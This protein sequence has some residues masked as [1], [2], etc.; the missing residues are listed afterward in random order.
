MRKLSDVLADQQRPD[1]RDLRSRS[2]AKRERKSREDWLA[3]LAQ[4]LVAL[5]PRHVERLA[6]PEPLADAI[7][8]ARAI[9]SPIARARQLRLVRRALREVDADALARRVQEVTSPDGRSG[10]RARLVEHWAGRLVAEGDAA[11]D[12]FLKDFPGATPT[13]LRQAARS[14]RGDRPGG[15]RWRKLRQVVAEA[16]EPEEP[17]EGEAGGEPKADDETVASLETETETETEAGGAGS[18]PR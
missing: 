4:D 12:A 7:R 16:L 18:E 3:T 15:P 14:A 9:T 8:D 13:G 17:R 10:R 2:D 11:L 1:P 5:R 6:L